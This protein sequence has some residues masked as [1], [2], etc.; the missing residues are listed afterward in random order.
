[1][2]RFLI[3]LIVL[4][5]VSCAK[6]PSL[7]NFPIDAPC[8]EPSLYEVV[9]WHT[10]AFES[11]RL[12]Q[13]KCA[14]GVN[15]IGYG[16]TS[17]GVASIPS[18]RDAE[19]E[20]SSKFTADFDKLSLKYPHLTRRQRL[21]L[22]SF[23]FNTGKIGKRLHRALRTG[24]N[25]KI[26]RALKLYVFAKGEKLPGLIRRRHCECELLTI[27]NC[28]LDSLRTL[29]HDKVMSDIYVHAN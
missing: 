29:L 15:T 1:M 18:V 2:K 27:S 6:A 12:Q 20:F 24:D 26:C 9:V 11:L 28:G 13:Y 4:L 23:Y 19:R 5:M 17:L 21:V 22:T 10:K 3:S 7:G 14:A 8:A 16:A 25:D